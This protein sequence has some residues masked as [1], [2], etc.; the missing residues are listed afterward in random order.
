MAKKLKEGKILGWYQG[1]SEYGARALGNR[2]I[3]ATPTSITIRDRVNK[4]KGR[5]LFRPVAPSVLKEYA[6]DFFENSNSNLDPYMLKVTYVKDIK[7]ELIEGVVH[8]DGTARIQTVTKE[9][10]PKYHDLI[11]EF[12]KLTGIPL[13]INTSFNAAGD[14]IVESVTD[15]INS[16]LKMNLDGLVCNNVYIE[17]KV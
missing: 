7:K 16:F 13:I 17:R 9:Q 5:E 3:I 4:L 1:R 2:S 6:H 12:Y 10:N 8:V 15:A 14:P 11:Y